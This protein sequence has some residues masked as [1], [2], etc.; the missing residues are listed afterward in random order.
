MSVIDDLLTSVAYLSDI[1]TRDIWGGLVVILGPG[2]PLSSVLFDYGITMLGG[3][4]VTDPIAALHYIGQGSSL[5][6]VPST[7]RITLLKDR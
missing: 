4:L 2:T 3:V 1:P 6:N 7:K 5:H